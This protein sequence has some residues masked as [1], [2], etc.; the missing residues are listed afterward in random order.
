MVIKIETKT[1]KKDNVS[2]IVVAL[3]CILTFIFLIIFYFLN[4]HRSIAIKKNVDGAA[5]KVTGNF[6]K[7]IGSFIITNASIDLSGNKNLFKAF[8]M[9]LIY[10][11]VVINYSIKE[12]NV[13][14][15]VILL[16]L[17][18]ILTL[19]PMF[20]YLFDISS[21]V[22]TI[23][24]EEPF[25]LFL[26]TIVIANLWYMFS[27]EVDVNLKTLSTNMSII[28]VLLY[29]TFKYYYGH[30]RSDA[31]IKSIGLTGAS[32]IFMASAPMYAY[33]TK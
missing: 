16:P 1:D 22:P 32:G 3:I 10:A 25:V 21:I 31:L 7:D 14:E 24:T 28:L 12:L 4:L 18:F 29:I 30:S 8:F 27:Y 33:T 20:K 9:I 5:F 23:T 2:P 17:I 26:L 19:P 11:F 13:A 15:L 6:F